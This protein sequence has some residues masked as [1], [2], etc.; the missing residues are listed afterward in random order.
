MVRVE[1][2][3]QDSTTVMKIEG[4]FVGH[5]VEDARSVVLSKRIP[6]R[7]IVDLS[8][9]SWVDSTGEE[10]LL[11]LARFGCSFVAGNAYASYVCE[12]LNLDVIQESAPNRDDNQMVF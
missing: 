7:L 3:Q 4:R 12:K 6:S 2:Q 5:F 8:G 10:L 11:W 1:F 9:L